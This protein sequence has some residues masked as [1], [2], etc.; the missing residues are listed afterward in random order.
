[1][2]NIWE[3]QIK[4][5]MR[6]HSTSIMTTIIKEEKPATASVGKD[7]GNLELLYMSSWNGN[8]AAAVENRVAIPPKVKHSITTKPKDFTPRYM[9]KT[10][11]NICSQENLY[12]NVHNSIIQKSQRV[13]TTQMFSN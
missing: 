3:M 13:E 2:L 8:G 9:P 11:E 5:T 6:Y 4:T 12:T 10:T 1:M 7:V